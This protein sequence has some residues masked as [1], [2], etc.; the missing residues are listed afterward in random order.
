V[1]GGAV[2]TSPQPCSHPQYDKSLNIGQTSSL[3]SQ[4]DA[5]GHCSLPH[6]QWYVEERPATVSATRL[7]QVRAKNELATAAKQTT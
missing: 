4:S 3:C 6:G 7:S 1:Y 5:L 2:L